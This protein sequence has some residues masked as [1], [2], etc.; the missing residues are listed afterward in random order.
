MQSGRR[1]SILFKWTYEHL[2]GNVILAKR[3]F[4]FKIAQVLL[5][6]CHSYHS[7]VF[8]QTIQQS[9]GRRRCFSFLL[10]FFFFFCFLG[11]HIDCSHFLP[12]KKRTMAHKDQNKY[13]TWYRSVWLVNVL[14][15]IFIDQTSV[16]LII[17]IFE[18]PTQTKCKRQS[19]Y[20]DKFTD[21]ILCL[22]IYFWGLVSKFWFL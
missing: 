4:I 21:Y 14:E 3:V 13:V 11:F 1:E 16:D 8:S 9:S 12:P 22:N 20:S 7:S 10:C 5:I 6:R 18:P 19:V 2:S 17:L 15:V